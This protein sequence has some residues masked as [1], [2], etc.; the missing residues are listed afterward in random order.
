MRTDRPSRKIEVAS[1]PAVYNAAGMLSMNT[2]T[3]KITRQSRLARLNGSESQMSY[4]Q[5]LCSG[6]LMKGGVSC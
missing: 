4:C 2:A 1:I 6:N 5:M 3:M